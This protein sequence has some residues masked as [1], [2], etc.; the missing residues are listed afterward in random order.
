VTGAINGRVKSI[1][2]IDPRKYKAYEAIAVHFENFT[3]NVPKGGEIHD[4]VYFDAR[5]K[6]GRFCKRAMV[7]VI[8]ESKKPAQANAAEAAT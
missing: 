8:D 1:A 5:T 4:Y 6:S 3:V 2:K 7:H